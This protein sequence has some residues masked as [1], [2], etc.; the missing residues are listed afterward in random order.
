LD[1]EGF[2]QGEFLLTLE[3]YS[4]D[5]KIY[6]SSNSAYTLKAIPMLV[7]QEPW[8]SIFELWQ[9]QREYERL[10]PCTMAS[11]KKTQREL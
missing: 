5:R 9:R 11:F 3:K 6:C 10:K 4:P 8:N 7:N 2:D 1:L